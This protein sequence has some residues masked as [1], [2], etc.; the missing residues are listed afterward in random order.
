MFHTMLLFG[1]VFS[2]P[3][4]LT[5][6]GNHAK[7]V[8][9]IPHFHLP[10]RRLHDLPQPLAEHR[11]QGGG[12]GSPGLLSRAFDPSHIRRLQHTAGRTKTS[13]ALGWTPLG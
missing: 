1:F 9:L 4:L 13:T 10:Q 12:V 7:D 3:S 5:A 6:L 11:L 2:D 8:R